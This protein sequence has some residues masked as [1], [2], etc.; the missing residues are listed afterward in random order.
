M[1]TASTP[2]NYDAG[3]E[4]GPDDAIYFDT[5]TPD[6]QTTTALVTRGNGKEYGKPERFAAVEQLRGWKAGYR[7]WQGALSRDG[8]LLF[9]V[10]SELDPA[11]QRPKLSDL[12]FT[13]RINGQWTAPQPL[14]AGVNTDGGENFPTLSPDG[15]ELIFVRDFRH[16]YRVSLAAAV[17]SEEKGK[18]KGKKP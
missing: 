1:A 18:T 7:L 3:P 4:F 12:W 10:V 15:R 11:T 9:V 13:R 14:G 16:F 2:G 8:T 6:W 17:E 5:T